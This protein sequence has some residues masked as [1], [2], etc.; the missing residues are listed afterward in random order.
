MVKKTFINLPEEKKKRITNAIVDEFASS[1]PEKIS[2]NRIIK[3]AGI[4]R[5]SFYQYFDDKV[6][7]IE[8]LTSSLV[9]HFLEQSKIVHNESNGDLFFTFCKLFDIICG[10]AEDQ[11]Q[12]RILKN[13]FSN[14]KVNDNLVMNYFVSRFSGFSTAE[15][16]FSYINTDKLKF[17]DKENIALLTRILCLTLKN[18]V[19]DVFVIGIEEETVRK[20]YQQMIEIIKYGAVKE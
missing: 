11:M 13:L 2:I 8:I 15:N 16:A 9:S 20:D 6:D 5:G 4:S 12:K 19:F 7:L 3:S 1:P 10:Y 18:A 14:L 17:S